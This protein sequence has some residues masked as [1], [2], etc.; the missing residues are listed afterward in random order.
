MPSTRVTLLRG[1][2]AAG[3]LLAAT[4]AAQQPLVTPHYYGFQLP[5]LLPGEAIEGELTDSDGQNFKDG[6]R[7]DLYG[8]T[9]AAGET[10]TVTVSTTAFEPVLSVFGPDGSFVAHADFGASFGEVSATFVADTSGRYVVVV[11]GWAD[12]DMGAY[13]V[14]RL[15]TAA[16][17]SEARAVTL[18]TTLD[19]RIT[20]DLP[21]LPVGFGGGAE[22]FSFELEEE[23][24]LLAAMRSSELDAYLTLYDATGAVVAENDDDGYSTDAMLVALLE[25]GSYVIAAST[26]FFGQVGE[27]TLTLEPYYRR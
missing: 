14:R 26:Y 18:P 10:H 8:L 17:P 12:Y 6:S 19:S 7:L 1:A 24:L 15:A 2:L 5:E 4:G 20:A 13:R 25:P 23:T 11:S 27:Y 9:A 21:P 22:Y 16:G 3:L